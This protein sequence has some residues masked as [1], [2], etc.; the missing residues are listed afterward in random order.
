MCLSF[1]RESYCVAAFC[2]ALCVVCSCCQS[3]RQ[4]AYVDHILGQHVSFCCC[5]WYVHNITFH[6][7]LICVLSSKSFC[8]V[9]VAQLL[10]ILHFVTPALMHSSNIKVQHC[11][12]MGKLW[13]V[14]GCMW[15]TKVYLCSLHTFSWIL[16]VRDFF[17]TNALTRQ[18][19][20]FVILNTEMD[21][22]G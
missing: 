20:D 21:S 5:F 6:C 10:D 17:Q 2:C 3:V 19:Q 16:D 9:I 12:E 22:T 11:S 4:P 1:V 15:P 7:K 8:F 14:V 13:P 18:Q